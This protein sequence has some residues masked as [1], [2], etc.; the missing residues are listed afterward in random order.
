MRLLIVPGFSKEFGSANTYCIDEI[1]EVIE[2][3]R[4][5][6]ITIAGDVIKKESSLL[7]QRKPLSILRKILRWPAV[8][9]YAADIIYQE[10]EHELSSNK[11]DAVLVSHMPYDGVYA[12]ICAKRKFPYVKFLLYELDPITY[13]IDKQR[14]SLGKYLY[15]MRVLAE[16][17]TFQS[18]DVVLHMECNQKKYNAA[19]YDR[20]R[21]KFVYLDFP[22][23][24]NKYLPPQTSPCDIKR[25]VKM[26]YTGKLMSHFR[27]PHYL[28][29]VL[30]EIKKELDIEVYFYSSG[31]CQN[32]IDDMVTS[33]SF[34]HQCGY[35]DKGTLQKEIESSDVLINIGNKMSDMLPS[36]LLNYIET[37]MPIL[38]VKNQANDACIPY[39]E[40]Y[41]LAQVIDEN[42]TVE[43]S[44]RCVINFLKDN[45]G[46]RMGSSDI[47]DRFEK[48][49]PEYSAKVILQ[50]IG[51]DRG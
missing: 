3:S 28:L 24:H 30:V 20:Y 45:L 48:N 43:E 40:R 37:G 1:V 8:D 22:L 27:S 34:I 35:V 51:L 36:K 26:I 14:K 49:T 6:Q 32:M 31:D 41:E 50:N 7:R 21:E 12:A 18:F 4:N 2:R 13:E 38:H 19:K 9:P 15:F 42:A 46:H 44:A 5:N 17:R 33:Y 16:K 29:M 39:L 47:V 25:R 23:I 10:M 11:Y